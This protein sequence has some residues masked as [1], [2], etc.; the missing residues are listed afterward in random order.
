MFSAWNSAQNRQLSPTSQQC[1]IF[2]FLDSNICVLSI[3]FVSFSYGRKDSEDTTQRTPGTPP[4][5]KRR[6]SDVLVVEEQAEHFTSDSA[7]RLIHDI[8]VWNGELDIKGRN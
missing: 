8:M 1:F 2:L 6:G 4:T 3:P 5:S 7:Q